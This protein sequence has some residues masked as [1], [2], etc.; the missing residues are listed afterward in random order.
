VSSVNY[1]KPKDVTPAAFNSL[2]DAEVEI[3]GHDYDMV[4]SYLRSVF[5]TDLAA[6]D[7]T[8]T[9]LQVAKDSGRS[10]ESVLKDMQAMDQLTLTSTLA[11]YLN[12][13]RDPSTLLGVSSITTPNYYVARQVLP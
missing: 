1:P 9:V 4:Y 11:F 3:N 7:F 5:N 8:A 10:A 12:R 6:G 2:Y 13:L